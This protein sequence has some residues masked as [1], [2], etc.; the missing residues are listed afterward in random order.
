MVEF[1]CDNCNCIDNTGGGNYWS[2]A[3]INNTLRISRLS[4]DEVIA[5]KAKYGL[6]ADEPLGR[7]CVACSP[8]GDG[9]WTRN[10]DRVFLP[11]GE[12]FVNSN[13]QIEHRKTGRTD[14]RDLATR[15]EEYSSKRPWEIS[16]NQNQK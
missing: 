12:F 6:G 13:G 9:T 16:P 1:I 15:I 4:E 8:D 5:L 3:H 10:F 14:Y 2:S 7:Y 11:K